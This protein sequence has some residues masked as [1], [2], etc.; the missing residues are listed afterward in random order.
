MGFYC[1][2]QQTTPDFLT[3]LTST[4][5]R[6]PREGFEKQVPHTPEE[7]ET[8]WKLSPEYKALKQELAEYE[9]KYP[10][11][12]ELL[13]DFKAN[14]RHVQSKHMF[15]HRARL[16]SRRTQWLTPSLSLASPQPARKSLHAQLRRPDQA[17]PSARLP[18]T[19]GRS[20]AH[21]SPLRRP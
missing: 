19:Q 5:E 12:G 8:R 17:L 20:V 7:F 9:S 6:R 4:L 3:G 13:E 14:R 10:V 21:V 11:N 1:P 18:E 2:E 16:L 15:V